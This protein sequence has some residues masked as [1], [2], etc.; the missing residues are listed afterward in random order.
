[1]VGLSVL[2]TK[3]LLL[4]TFDSSPSI[5]MSG[6]P[7]VVMF[8]FAPLPPTRPIAHMTSFLKNSAAHAGEAFEP[9]SRTSV[10]LPNSSRRE[11]NS[12][13]SAV[14]TTR[15]QFWSSEESR[16][17][18]R[19]ATTETVPWATRVRMA[20]KKHKI[21]NY[22]NDRTKC[23]FDYPRSKAAGLES[24]GKGSFSQSARLAICSH[25]ENRV[26]RSAAGEEK[27]LVLK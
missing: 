22:P 3:T 6:L 16:L 9:K 13:L 5:F 14:A 19:D 12:S 2:E 7:A 24:V 18:R 4:G 23:F 11:L 17:S 8:L 27:K 25:G 21:L 1:M 15:M 26:S 10:C 20:G